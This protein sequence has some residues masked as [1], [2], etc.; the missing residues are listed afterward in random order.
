MTIPDLLENIQPSY[1]SS[2]LAFT[3]DLW[4]KK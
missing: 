4:S 1:S 2:M 3:R